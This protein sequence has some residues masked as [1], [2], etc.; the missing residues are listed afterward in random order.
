MILKSY[1]I[2]E[3][4]IEVESPKKRDNEPVSN[5][6][7]WVSPWIDVIICYQRKKLIHFNN[8]RILFSFNKNKIIIIFN[9]FKII[10]FNTINLIKLIK[11]INCILFIDH[12]KNR[13]YKII[14]LSMIRT[15][16]RHLQV[17]QHMLNPIPH[18]VGQRMRLLVG[19]TEG[20]G[21]ARSFQWLVHLEVGARHHYHRH[22]IGS[23]SHLHST[24]I[25]LLLLTPSDCIYKSL[26]FF[27]SFI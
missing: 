19:A 20:C 9:I 8:I 15:R 3:L 26:N 18:S 27:W 23:C 12:G 16:Q 21:L 25:A 14:S 10:I 24:W 11:I 5:F 4:L 17:T 13:I 1:K 22:R 6:Q 7:C 2:I